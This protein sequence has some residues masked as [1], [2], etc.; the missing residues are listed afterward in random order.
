[1]RPEGETSE[2]EL[3]AKAFQEIS[4]EIIREGLAKVL[5]KA[6]L[7]YSR[8]VRGAVPLIGVLYLES[9]TPQK[10]FT[11]ICISVISMLASRTTISFERARLFEAMSETNMWMIGHRQ[12]GRIG[13]YRWNTSTLL[14]RGPSQCSRMCDFGTDLNPVPFKSFRHGGRMW[15]AEN[16]MPGM[17]FTFALRP[18]QSAQ[19][20]GSC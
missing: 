12:I 20:S 14:S 8:V 13:R 6:A 16:K 11:P 3:I 9:E 10:T 4:K 5:L 1:M 7:G 2:L 17:T 18:R 19:M 15:V